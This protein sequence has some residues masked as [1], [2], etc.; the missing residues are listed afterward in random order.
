[1]RS[2]WGRVYYTNLWASAMTLAMTL[3]TEPGVLKTMRWDVYPLAALAVSCSLGVAM[4]YFAFA[5]RKAVS[6]T[7]FTVIGNVKPA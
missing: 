2:N 7:S 1:M 5:C 4:S 6:A 3:A